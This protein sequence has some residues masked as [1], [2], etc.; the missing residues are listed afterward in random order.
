MSLSSEVK[1]IV[2]G[3][4][5]QLEQD[6]GF[7]AKPYLDT[8]GVPTFGHGLT[9][10]TELESLRI[11]EDRVQELYWLLSSSHRWFNDLTP[12]RRSVILNMTY[13]LGY[14]GLLGFKKMIA[15]IE[16]GDFPA[17]GA[18]MLNSKYARQV[19]ERAGRLAVQMVEG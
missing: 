16:R 5:A 6:E 18:E 2:Q 15:A 12:R 19:G 1:T 8:V 4:T 13:N 7:R 14:K 10:I 3:T 9:Y 11:V 17:A